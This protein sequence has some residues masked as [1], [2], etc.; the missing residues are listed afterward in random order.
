MC[1]PTSSTSADMYGNLSELRRARDQCRVKLVYK[2]QKLWWILLNLYSKATEDASRNELDQ[3][4]RQLQ[5]GNQLELKDIES[6]MDGFP[7][8]P[9]SAQLISEI[10]VVSESKLE[11][12]E[13]EL[14][15]ISQMTL[16]IANTWPQADP[17]SEF[18]K[19]LP[20][21]GR[22]ATK[23][24]REYM[25]ILKWT[26]LGA[27]IGTVFD[28][29]QDEV[30]AVG[31]PKSEARRRLRSWNPLLESLDSIEAEKRT[32]EEY[33][34]VRPLIEE[35]EREDGELDDTVPDMQMWERRA[36]STLSTENWQR[37]A[38]T[39]MALRRHGRTIRD[40]RL[41]VERGM[42]ECD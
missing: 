2:T 32:L 13:T 34:W 8:V 42:R 4:I 38:A 6:R 12:I 18:P 29:L 11:E 28:R 37:R 39:V 15:R 5:A 3:S 36:A 22:S 14:E 10:E 21:L 24:F 33:A 31:E 35:F 40:W 27:A 17:D 20:K 25:V 19:D 16:E 7:E 23:S 26:A 41:K 1:E 30:I 9:L